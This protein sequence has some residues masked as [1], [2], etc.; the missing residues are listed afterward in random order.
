MDILSN[1]ALTLFGGFVLLLFAPELGKVI[2]VIR[3]KPYETFV[4]VGLCVVIAGVVTLVF[5]KG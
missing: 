5:L 1:I 3:R 4:V 2:Q